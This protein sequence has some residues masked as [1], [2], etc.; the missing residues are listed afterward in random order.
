MEFSERVKSL[1][2]YGLVPKVVDNVLGGNPVSYRVI[3]NAKSGN[4]KGYSVVKA[5]KV[6]NSSTASSF[7]GLD[8]FSASPLDTKIRMEFQMHGLRQ[9]VALSG[10]E[11]V[12]NM[13]SEAKVTDM[14]KESLEETQQELTDY[15]GDLLYGD[16]TGNSDKDFTGLG[17]IVDDGTDVSTIGGQSRSTYPVLNATRTASGGTLSLAKM[18]T[19]HSAIS[20]GTPNTTP[21]LLVANDTVWNLFETLWLPTVS[22]TQSISLAPSVVGL[23]GGLQREQGLKGQVGFTALAYKG[24][25]FVADPKATSQT[26]YML[27]E[28]QL[29]WYGWDA[30]GVAGYKKVS[31]GSET[32]EGVYSEAPGQFSGFSWSGLMTPTNQ[33][34]VVGVIQLLGELTSFAPKRH[35]RLTGITGV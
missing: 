3:G 11:M 31:L 29:E 22:Q 12:A 32:I 5:V 28:Q 26:L 30:M 14:I 4:A 20:D 7:A 9:P 35:G 10:M 16:G 34:G 6:T 13:P 21:T 18:A 25:P 33:F 24:I 2:A 15:I 17:A 19:L 23:K 27:N 8:T 1:T